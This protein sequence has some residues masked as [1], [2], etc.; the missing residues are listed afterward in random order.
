MSA[1]MAKQPVNVDFTRVG[2]AMGEFA[3]RKFP[4]KWGPTEKRQV[5]AKI[6][7]NYDICIYVYKYAIFVHVYTYTVYRYLNMNIQ[8]NIYIYIYIYK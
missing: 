6:S 8:M 1:A 5:G 4:T 2:G 7:K 3:R